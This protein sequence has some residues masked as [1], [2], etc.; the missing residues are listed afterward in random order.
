LVTELVAAGHDPGEALITISVAAAR[1]ESE[2]PRRVELAKAT[3]EWVDHLQADRRLPGNQV[4][5]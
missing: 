4:V 3:T 2:H 5:N 1:L